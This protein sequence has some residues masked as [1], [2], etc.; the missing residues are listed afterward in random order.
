MSMKIYKK[1]FPIF[2]L[3]N[4]KMDIEINSKFQ[5]PSVWSLSQKQLFIDSLLRNY[6]VPKIY[7][8]KIADN[9]EQYTVIDGQQRLRAIWEYFAGGFNTGKDSKPINFGECK[10]V[11]YEMLPIDLMVRLHTYNMDLVIIETE[12]D[13]AIRDMFVRFQ[14]GTSLKDQEKRKIEAGQIGE[15][16]QSVSGHKFFQSVAFAQS[17][18]DVELVA[19]QIMCMELSSD[20]TSIK[21]ADLDTMYQ[22]HGNLE[23]DS[24][25]TKA[26]TEN[27]NHFLEIFPRS[28][29]ELDKPNVITLYCLIRILKR[30]FEFRDLKDDLRSWFVDFEKK[31]H[32]LYQIIESGRGLEGADVHD[33]VAYREKTTQGAESAESIEFRTNFLL[34]RFLGKFTHLNRKDNQMFFTEAQKRCIYVRDKGMC[35]LKIT[36]DGSEILG[37]ENWSWHC[38]HKVAWDDGGLT[39][40]ENGQVSCIGCAISRKDLTD[41]ELQDK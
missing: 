4:I 12:R 2:S 11:P 37:K 34:H 5:R 31:R 6:D 25:V 26:I 10:D 17:K 38:D 30:D 27:L 24:A 36:C 13:D 32:R 16:I 29:P 18:S 40:V 1:V 8:R 15:L 9:P 23:S 20:F 39:S 41:I 14:S 22:N 35:R 21:N 19:S 7:L 33:Y 28:F 3:V